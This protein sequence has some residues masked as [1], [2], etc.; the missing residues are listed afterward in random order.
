MNAEIKSL[1]S[2]INLDNGAN[3]EVVESVAVIENLISDD[4][5]K[6]SSFINL[7]FPDGYM[8][9]VRKD[10]ISAFYESTE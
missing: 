3:Y 2:I 10:R 4:F 9:N 1:L 8:C 5:I 6:G 7:H